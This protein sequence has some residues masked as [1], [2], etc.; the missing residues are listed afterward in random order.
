MISLLWAL[1]PVF[2]DDDDD[3]DDDGHA[4]AQVVRNDDDEDDDDV[5]TFLPTRRYQRSHLESRSMI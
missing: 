4:R 1:L 3:D 5:I 2:N